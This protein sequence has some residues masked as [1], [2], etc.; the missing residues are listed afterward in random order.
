MHGERDSQK[1]KKIFKSVKKGPKRCSKVSKKEPGG[2]LGS[3]EEVVLG[4]GAFLGVQKGCR[5]DYVQ[6]CRGGRRKEN[7]VL[8]ST[9]TS[10]SNLK[11][12]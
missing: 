1:G 3:P 2:L 8:A 12:K 6:E 10:F 7:H 9:T 5:R 4:E 11:E